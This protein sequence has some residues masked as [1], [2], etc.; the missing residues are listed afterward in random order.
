MSGTVTQKQVIDLV[1]N[2]GKG[3]FDN[4][5]NTTAAV[6]YIQDKSRSID[7]LVEIAKAFF[8]AETVIKAWYHS[9]SKE[10]NKVY[11]K[12]LLMNHFRNLKLAATKMQFENLGILATVYRWWS[13]SSTQ[14]YSNTDAPA[15]G[16][17]LLRETLVQLFATFSPVQ[18]PQNDGN[19]TG[20]GFGNDDDESDPEPKPKLLEEAIAR[21]AKVAG[22]EHVIQ[23][24][25]GISKP[26]NESVSTEADAIATYTTSKLIRLPK[27]HINN[28]AKA[29]SRLS[30]IERT[31]SP[32][33]DADRSRLFSGFS[34]E[35]VTAAPAGMVVKKFNYEYAD[36]STQNEALSLNISKR[37]GS[38]VYDKARLAIKPGVLGK[39]V[40]DDVNLKRTLIESLAAA[41]RKAGAQV[42]TIWSDNPATAVEI[43][44]HMLAEG[45][46]I[47]IDGPTLNKI[48]TAKTGWAPDSLDSK[49]LELIEDH[50]ALFYD[51]N[52][53]VAAYA[54]VLKHFEEQEIK[55]IPV[56]TKHD[57]R[58]RVMAHIA[59]ARK[60]LGSLKDKV[61]PAEPDSDS[62]ST[63]TDDEPAADPS[64]KGLAV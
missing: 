9:K 37:P 13:A 61:K 31:H 16:G 29:S 4:P 6:A 42:I 7:E 43:A 25:L 48:S 23:T 53:R 54:A 12:Q 24:A 51:D 20:G 14:Y 27:A 45:F 22:T 17:F 46:Q 8:D 28:P 19:G 57:D 33:D 2:V 30:G 49:R 50:R 21:A 36:G 35:A 40:E 26:R 1:G 52:D 59:H 5:I 44:V 47:K 18:A 34:E 56:R 58:G 63:D 11:K 39:S 10:I 64:G 41:A 32:R 55:L 60:V 62:D 15:D 3:V 38:T